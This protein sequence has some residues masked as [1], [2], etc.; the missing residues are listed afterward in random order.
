[1]Q[2]FMVN[3]SELTVNL[4]QIVVNHIVKS[5]TILTTN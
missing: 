4:Y 3:S 2:N 5:T 1:M